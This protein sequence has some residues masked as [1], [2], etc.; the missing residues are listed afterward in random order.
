MKETTLKKRAIYYRKKGYSYSIISKK[1]KLS[2]STLSDWLKEIPFKPNKE[3]M[4]RIDLAR[5]K[6][7]QTRHDKKIADIKNAKE[8]AKKELGK[9]TKRDLWLLG[10]GLYWGEGDKSSSE[11]VKIM[12]SDPL[13]IKMMIK[14]F[15]EIC[16]LN[17]NNFRAAVH[18]YPDNDIKEAIEYWSKITKIPKSQFGKTQIDIRKNKSKKKKNKLPYGTIKI[19]IKS[20]RKKEFGVFLNRRIIGWIEALKNQ[21]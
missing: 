2:K 6:S 12:N 7:I 14:W 4:N 16:K 10:I 5:L 17:Y 11:G 3:T 15:K 19:T 20:N 1:L 18:I 9:I 21:C 8:I 13:M